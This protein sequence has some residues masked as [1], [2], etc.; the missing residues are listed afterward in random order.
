MNII[1]GT[2]SVALLLVGISSLAMAQSTA[3]VAVS[4]PLSASAS[5]PADAATEPPAQTGAPGDVIR[6]SIT[7]L[8]Q[9][10]D[11][12]E[13]AGT[14]PTLSEPAP[15]AHPATPEQIRELVKL[16]NTVEIAHEQMAASIK[17][18]RASSPDYFPASFW[19]DM[20]RAMMSINIVDL[21]IPLYQKYYSQEDM[22]VA[23]AFFRTPA[24]RRM[25]SVQPF[26]NSIYIKTLAQ[27]GAQVGEKIG[28]KY[29][30]QLE[31]LKNQPP[32]G[33]D[34]VVTT[35]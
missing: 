26:I 7:P 8:P 22:N 15:P 10:I 16:T 21:S 6:H 31:K 30:E 28:I 25:V 18:M 32:S 17:Q 14:T 5:A 19:I 2:L 34:V 33:M 20:Q 11:L 24:G 35:N 4:A 1:H 9:T 29:K 3:P 23:L 12:P 13:L 27:A